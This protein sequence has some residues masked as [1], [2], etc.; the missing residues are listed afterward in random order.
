MELS[1]RVSKAS[2]TV[3][4]LQANVDG[5]DLSDTVYVTANPQFERNRTIW[6]ITLNETINV[7]LDGGWDDETGTVRA[8]AMTEA[9]LDAVARFPHRRPDVHYMQPHYP[10]V[11][12]ETDFDKDHLQQ[13]DGDSDGPTG[14]NV[15]NQ[16]IMGDLHISRD[17]LRAIYVEN[18]EHVLEHVAELLEVLSGKTVLTATTRTMSASERRRFRFGSRA[19]HAGC[20]TNRWFACRGWNT[21]EENDERYGL[22]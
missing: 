18:L 13:I 20:T 12:A 16:K 1:S 9:A 22:G 21:S 15:W 7:W 8:E 17:G 14:E 10:F 19:I 2:F 5:R 6:E 3:E 11:P 4:W